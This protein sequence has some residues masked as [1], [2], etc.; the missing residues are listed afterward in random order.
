M[1]GH[2]YYYLYKCADLIKNKIFLI[3]FSIF[4][5]LY[6][7]GDLI[8]SNGIKY[9]IMPEIKVLLCSPCFTS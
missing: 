2:I 4:M 6:S 7:V 3:I 5:I 1:V 9:R 8:S